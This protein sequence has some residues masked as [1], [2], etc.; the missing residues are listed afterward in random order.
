VTGADLFP[1]AV[2]D[3]WVYDGGVTAPVVTVRADAIRRVDGQ[4]G[5]VVITEDPVDG[6]SESVYVVGAAAVRQVPA[7]TG[8]PLVNA[9]GPLDVMRFPL[10]AGDRWTQI[11]KTVDTGM[12]FDGDGRQE[13]ATVR[14]EVEVI[15][16]ESVTTPV[17]NFT[18]SL[19]QRTTLTV[20]VQLT[21]VPQAVTVVTTV[22]DWYAPDIGP[23]RAQIV[24]TSQGTTETQTLALTSYRVG[25]RHSGTV[26]PTVQAFTPAAG[27][28]TGRG[29]AATL[30]Q[31][32]DGAAR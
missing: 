29:L 5:I 20:V 18:G 14:S 1:L 4:D 17:A 6:A 9:I 8:D 23:V 21:S 31:L 22:D 13:R 10:R 32:L 26:A 24:M 15:G 2:G 7:D 27:G 12:D 16:L 3:R 28:T 25:T 30:R 19:H 11:D